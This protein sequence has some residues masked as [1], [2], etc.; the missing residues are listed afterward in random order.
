[1][2][3]CTTAS[4][5]TGSTAVS[6]AAASGNINCNTLN[7]FL[8]GKFSFTPSDW[9]DTR[10]TCTSVQATN[11]ARRAGS[12]YQHL[13]YFG[14]SCCGG[15]PTSGPS[16][17]SFNAG[18]TATAMGWFTATGSSTPVLVNS[19]T[20]APS[21]GSICYVNK[22]KVRYAECAV[23]SSATTTTVTTSVVAMV[24]AALATRQ[25]M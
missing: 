6:P 10:I 25:V 22:A 17:S 13:W 9:T 1:M 19:G 11:W 3:M 14:P 18:A 15:M 23:S 2:N 21:A 5:F 4:D 16:C 20:V 8:L 24:I 7:T 12:M